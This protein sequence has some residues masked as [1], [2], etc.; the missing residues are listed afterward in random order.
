MGRLTGAGEVEVLFCPVDEFAGVDGVCPDDGDLGVHQA[1][2]EEDFL[3]GCGVV[4][5]GGG[6]YDHEG[7]AGGVDDQVALAA[8][9]LLARVVAEGGLGDGLGRFHALG[10]DHG[11]HGSGVFAHVATDPAGEMVADLADD[12]GRCPA[13]HEP[14][15]RAPAWEICR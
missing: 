15:D 14:P 7:Q 8:V 12:P 4:E 11:G 2:A 5:V 10:A 9:D 13:G 1:E 3:G 6:D